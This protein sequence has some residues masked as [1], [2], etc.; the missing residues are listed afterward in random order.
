MTFNR[1]GEAIKLREQGESIK[2]IA[3]Q[4]KAAQS[5][6]SIWVRDVKLT[7]EQKT[8]LKN[9]THTQNVIDARR[10]SRLKNGANARQIIIDQAYSEIESISKKELLLIGVSLYWAEGGKTQR[11]VRFSNGDPRMIKLMI[12]FFTELCGVDH[13]KLRAHIHV[14]ESLDVKGAERYWQ[15]ITGIN[16]SKFYKTYNKPNKS[17]K[18]TRNSLP[19]GVCDIYVGDYKLFLKIEGWT[20]AIYDATCK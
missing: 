9:N 12:R 13:G 16:A 18:G 7:N 1:K 4:I 11:S 5:S 6:V 2:S 17:S 10:Q 19:Y 3:N 20:K 14:H 8:K 15:N